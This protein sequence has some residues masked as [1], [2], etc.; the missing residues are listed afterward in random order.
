MKFKLKDFWLWGIFFVIIILSGWAANPQ[1]QVSISVLEPPTPVHSK[2]KTLLAY[3]IYL[4]NEQNENGLKLQKIEV[5]DAEYPDKILAA[6]E[7][8]DLLGNGILITKDIRNVKD[9]FKAIKL[10]RRMDKDEDTFLKKG[11]GALVF[12][13][14]EIDPSQPPPKSLINRATFSD[15][16]LIKVCKVNVRNVDPVVIA[17]PLGNKKWVT[18]GA[19]APDSYHRRAAL[20]LDGKFYVAQRFAVDY[21]VIDDKDR[22]SEGDPTKNQ[23]YFCFGEE[24]IS[25][26]D[27]I[28]TST[29]D[30]IPENVATVRPKATTIE[31]LEGNYVV[32]DIGNGNYAFYAHLQPGSVR[33]K[34]GDTV[35]RGQVLG[36]L[37][38]TGNSDA[39]HLHMHICNGPDPV[40]SQGLP[41][42][43]KSFELLGLTGDEVNLD[44]GT[45][46]WT[47]EKKPE[48]LRKVIPVDRYVI[49]FPKE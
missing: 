3:E 45:W 43:F 18:S 42:V 38:N 28:V 46:S 40:R 35:K 49:D 5:V 1:G 6:Y 9:V 13:W 14:I 22:L 33:V 16:E 2:D 4:I 39:P 12:V 17:P 44:G 32:V 34:P 29:Q 30:D 19:P 21:M 7:G 47:P 31:K 48:I 36:L 11:M 24:I 8:K 15:N 20:P 41:F 10:I 25:V 23:S 27:G 37:G 26:A